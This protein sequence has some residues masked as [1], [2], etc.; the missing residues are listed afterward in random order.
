MVNT[1]SAVVASPHRQVVDTPLDHAYVIDTAC[2]LL[3]LS[4]AADAAVWLRYSLAITE[5]RTRA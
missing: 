3:A 5:P 4:T 2:R 1:D